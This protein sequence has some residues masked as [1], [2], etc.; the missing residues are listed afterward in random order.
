MEQTEIMRRFLIPTLAV[1]IVVAL[2]IAVNPG[3]SSQSGT[4]GTGPVPTI[5]PEPTVVPTAT[6]DPRIDEILLWVTVDATAQSE[7]GAIIEEEQER[8][9]LRTI[10][11]ATKVDLLIAEIESINQWLSAL[12]SLTTAEAS[13]IRDLI[14]GLDDQ[15]MAFFEEWR[16]SSEPTFDEILAKLNETP[17]PGTGGGG[18]GICNQCPVTQ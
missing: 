3:A 6:P 11:V 13:A 1:G 2:T 4:G 12:T 17:V 10:E 7:Q 16:L 15:E 9:R 8:E 18:I 5:V 14:V